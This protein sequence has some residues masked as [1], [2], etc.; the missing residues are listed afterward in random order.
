MFSHPTLCFYHPPGPIFSLQPSSA[1]HQEPMVQ[2]PKTKVLHALKNEWP[3]ETRSGE[4][5]IV[6]VA[7]DPA[8]TCALHLRDFLQRLKDGELSIR[9]AFCISWI[10]PENSG[11]PLSPE[12]HLKIRDLTLLSAAQPQGTVGDSHHP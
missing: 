10:V 7:L 2:A 3:K 5:Q 1:Q 11:F 8:L 9:R 4:G 6:M 12:S